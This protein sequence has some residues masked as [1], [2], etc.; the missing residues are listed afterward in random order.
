MRNAADY[1]AYIKS[2]LISAFHITDFITIREEAQ[3]QKGL[4]RYRVSLDDESLLEVFEF[5]TIT[6]DGVQVLKYSFHWQD[7]N[8]NLLKR[9]DNASH[10][11]EISTYPHH[12]HD[13]AEDAVF[14]HPPVTVGDILK[15]IN[16]QL[17]DSA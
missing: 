11:P 7:H 13:S 1:L 6:L 15:N 16:E 5:F 9:W 3:E 14:P 2:L 8:G 10:H 4:F 12:L 17:G